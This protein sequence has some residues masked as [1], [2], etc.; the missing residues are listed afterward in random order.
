ME[1]AQL[2]M[3]F[4]NEL[5]GHPQVL[6]TTAS[7]YS[8]A[9]YGWMQ[10]G[11]TD[12]QNVFRRFKFNVIDTDFINAMGLQ[13]IKGRP[14]SKDNAADSNAILVNEALVKE[15]GWK[16]PIGQ[17]LPGKYDQAIIG[18]VKDFHLESLHATIKPAI[19]ALKA[20]SIFS[21]S[22]DVTYDFS[23]RP[24]ISV[25]FKEGNIQGH[26]STLKTTWKTVAGDRDFEYQFLDE[27]L[28]TAYQ[29]EQRLGNIVQYASVLSI[30]IA[31]MGLFGLATLVVVR[32]TKE[33][34]IRKVL[35]AEVTNIVTLL[36]KDF[37]VLVLVASLIAF[38]IAW[39]A[40]NKW[41]QDFAYRID[42]PIALFILAAG[43]TLLIALL[44]VSIQAIRAALMNPVKSLRTE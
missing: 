40:L 14:F 23:P 32:R 16:D 1:G 29:Q 12:K 36:S 19:L 33:I 3:R 26:L 37:V 6:N 5:A 7:L 28:A 31:C 39:W 21:Q 8:M 43:I 18:V 9:E 20:D 15:Y 10:L 44:T 38:P 41:L 25:R 42:V 2:A 34:G 30:F 27:A 22:S 17:K 4:K 24:R 11:Y 35:G 13:V